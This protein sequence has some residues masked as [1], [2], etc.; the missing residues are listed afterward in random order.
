MTTYECSFGTTSTNREDTNGCT[1]CL[2]GETAT[3]SQ[4]EYNVE[5]SGSVQHLNHMCIGCQAGSIL[6]EK[7]FF[8]ALILSKDYLSCLVWH[9]FVA[10]NSA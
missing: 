6:F 5:T 9:S 1:S 2:Y 4:A 10:S 8:S 7:S 3:S